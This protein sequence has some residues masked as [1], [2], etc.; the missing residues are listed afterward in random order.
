MHLPVYGSCCYLWLAWTRRSY[1]ELSGSDEGAYIWRS[2]EQGRLQRT[3][4]YQGRRKAVNGAPGCRAEPRRRETTV[5]TVKPTDENVISH[6]I[7]ALTVGH[8][9]HDPCLWPMTHWPISEPIYEPRDPWFIIE[10][11]D[12][13]VTN[14]PSDLT[15]N[16]PWPTWP[17]THVTHLTHHW[18]DP[19]R[20]NW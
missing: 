17:V 4:D 16:W 10:L 3:S 13:H 8:V 18:T 15:V 6:S 1:V 5:A 7:W 19:S 14:D 12:D 11:T 9:T 20:F 2:P